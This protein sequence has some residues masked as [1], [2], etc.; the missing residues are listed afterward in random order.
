[1]GGGDEEAAHGTLGAWVFP[2]EGALSR[3]PPKKICVWDML[4][5]SRNLY[6]GMRINSHPRGYPA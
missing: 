2:Q 1:M 3:K 4:P 6:F 5:P